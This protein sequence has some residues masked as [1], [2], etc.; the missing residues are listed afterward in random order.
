MAFDGNDYFDI[1]TSLGNAL[2]DGLADI[3][4][5]MWVNIASGSVNDGIFKI[6]ALGANVG[7]FAIRVVNDARIQV[8]FASSNISKSYDL[9]AA[10]NW[11]HIVIVKQGTTALGYINGVLATPVSGGGSSIPSTFDF[12]GKPAFIGL[13]WNTDSGLLFNG[14]MDEVAIWNSALTR[15]QIK[16]D[17]Y[18]ASTTANKSADFI[19]NPNLPD[20]VAWYRMGD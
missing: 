8:Y 18:E 4:I 9:L 11:N 1:G 7:E 16:F 10:G 3:T 19:N 20:P 13:Y 12:S 14:N 17:I 5:S 15:N 2:G 6:G